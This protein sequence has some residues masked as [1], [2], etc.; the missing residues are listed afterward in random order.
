VCDFAWWKNLEAK[1]T[2]AQLARENLIEMP[3]RVL[4]RGNDAHQLNFFFHGS[5]IARPSKI[6]AYNPDHDPCQRRPAA[7]PGD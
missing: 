6:S 4:V 3:N 7:A 5:K 1:E 2:A